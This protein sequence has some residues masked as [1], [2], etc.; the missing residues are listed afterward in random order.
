M[1]ELIDGKV[2]VKIA[3]FA[4]IMFAMVFCSACAAYGA[5]VNGVL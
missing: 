5:Y 2:A 3:I 4:F 1:P